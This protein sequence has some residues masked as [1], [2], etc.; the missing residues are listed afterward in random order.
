MQGKFLFLGSGGSMGVP[1][2]G[3]HCKVCTSNSPNNKRLR[4]SGLIQVGG[5]NF[6]IDVGP[7]FREQALKY[8]IK[9]LDGLLITHSHFDHIG[10][11]DDLRVFYFIQKK[12]VP[13]LVS[14]ETYE[15]LKVRY[16]YMMRP[17]E[18]GKS[19]FAQLDFRLLEDDFGRVDFEGVMWDY[20]SYYQADMKVTG[21]R[22][23][24]LAYISD[25]RKFEE[26][27]VD[28]LQGV[29]TIIISALRYTPSEVHFSIDEAID[30]V[31]RVGAKRTY[32]THIAHDLDHEETN[33][34]LPE[35]VRM[36]YDG[37]EF[38]FSI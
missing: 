36:G 4:P 26:R 12:A 23:G 2:V 37:L 17:L 9:H 31:R 13:C 10:G 15:E 22:L 24:S 5:K 38:S 35:D 34:K 19:A 11:L 14:K 20:V 16:H 7:D 3:C 18:K 33:A 21:F 32:F 28:A 1:V 30:F 6:L 25:I 27:V 8:Q 29:E